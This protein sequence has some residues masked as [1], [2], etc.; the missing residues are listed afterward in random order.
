MVM[1]S[2]AV[3]LATPWTVAHQTPLS[4]GFSRQEHWGRLPFPFLGD[5][6]DPGMAPVSPESPALAGRFY[7]PEPL[8]K[9]SS[10]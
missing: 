8:G 5:L 4:V 2:H 3:L 10:V 9:L 6:P 1:L 7:Y